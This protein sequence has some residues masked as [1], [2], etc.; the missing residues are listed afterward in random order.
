MTTVHSAS[1]TTDIAIAVFDADA[2]RHH[3]LMVRR[4]HLGQSLRPNLQPPKDSVQA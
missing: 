3:S 1:I 4:L 2:A